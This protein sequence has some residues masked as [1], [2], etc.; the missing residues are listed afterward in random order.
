MTTTAAPAIFIPNPLPARI[1]ALDSTI[2]EHSA[3]L[4]SRAQLIG[5]ITNG[6]EFRDAE[7][8]YSQ[9]T[10]L[11]KEVDQERLEL[12]RPIINLGKQ[13]DEVAG[14]ALAPLV[15]QRTGLRTKIDA[16]ITAE[17]D[18]RRKEAEECQARM[19]AE[20]AERQRLADEARRQ[21]AAAAPAED[22]PMPGEEP[23]A[24]PHEPLAT[25][26]P[27]LL[28]SSVL[29]KT[30][31]KVLVIDDASLI[32]RELMDPNEKKIDALLRAGIPVPGCRL[33]VAPGFADK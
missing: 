29:K 12:K 20:Q 10:A 15:I 30:N 19:R 4:V 8:V 2:L 17:N 28:K 27:V 24:P 22:A 23:T 32:P 16:W 1:L 13:L 21:A 26:A 3:K 7:I 9:I 18:R 6:D 25:V 5:T 11:A 33:D 31:R 14:E